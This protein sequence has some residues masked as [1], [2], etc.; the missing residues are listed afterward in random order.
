MSK[1]LTVSPT[2]VPG[3]KPFAWNNFKKSN[4]VSIGWMDVDLTGWNIEK[5]ISYLNI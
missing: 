3:K 1:F 4:Y 2:H 5:I